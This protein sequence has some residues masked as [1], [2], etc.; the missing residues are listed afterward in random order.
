MLRNLGQDSNTKHDRH[1]VGGEMLPKQ[2]LNPPK[3]QLSVGEE[4]P[5]QVPLILQPEPTKISQMVS[6]S[7]Q[8]AQVRWLEAPKYGPVKLAGQFS[9]S[10][11]LKNG[12]KMRALL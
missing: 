5:S 7:V 8:Y 12:P 2:Y 10:P 3:I 11:A 1:E 9:T 6:M 4:I